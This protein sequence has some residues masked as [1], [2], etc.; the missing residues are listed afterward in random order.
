MNKEMMIN[1]GITLVVVV[2]GMA[3]YDNVVAPR[4]K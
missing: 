2:V 4:L 3:I 1:A